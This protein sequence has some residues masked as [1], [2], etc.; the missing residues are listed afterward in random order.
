MRKEVRRKIKKLKLGLKN[1]F[2]FKNKDFKILKYFINKYKNQCVINEESGKDYY[3]AIRLEILE[4]KRLV[5]SV[6]EYNP[7][8]D[9]SVHIFHGTQDLGYLKL[10]TN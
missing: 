1:H 10:F 7:L 4:D 8:D 9:M 3:P 5:L 6:E 2:N